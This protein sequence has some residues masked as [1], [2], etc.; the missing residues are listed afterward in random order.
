LAQLELEVQRDPGLRRRSELRSA[1][2]DDC[3]VDE[4]RRIRKASVRIAARALLINSGGWFVSVVPIFIG[5]ALYLGLTRWTS[6][7]RRKIKAA[8]SISEVDVQRLIP[9][10]DPSIETSTL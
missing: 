1:T 3:P 5:L 2:L 8:I 9:R 7:V 10:R 6:F 4:L